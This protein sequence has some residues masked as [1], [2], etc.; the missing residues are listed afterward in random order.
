MRLFG[1]APERGAAAGDTMPFYQGGKWHLFFSQPP[2]GAWDY[3]ERARVS[4]AYLRSDDL[5]TWE[6]MPD[7]FG[8]GA[9]GNCD[10]DGIWTGSLIE[11]DGVFHFFYT[12]YNRQ[13]ASPQTI[14]KATS[15]DLINWSK[16][17]ANP[18]ITPDDRWYETVDW[19]DP[20]VYCDQ[21][22]GRFG[23]L[24]SARLKSGPQFR[25]G[26]IAVAT[27]DDLESW[28]VGPPL[29]SSRLTHCPECPEIFKL[30]D[31]WYLVE[32]RYS[33]RMQ[34]VYRVAPSPDGPWESRKLD[35]L[36]GR[37]FYAAKSTSDENRRISFAW[38]PFRKHHGPD[39]NWV[40]GGEL[41][42]PR[43]LISHADGTL[44]CR[45]PPEVAASYASPVE[46]QL[47][48]QL[49]DWREDGAISCD[50]T[51]SYAYVFLNGPD[52]NDVLLDVVIEPGGR[53]EAVGILIDPLGGDQLESG[54]FLSIEPMRERVLID[55]WPAAMD[56]LW[57]SLVLKER[58]GIEV[59]QEI[60]SPLVERPLMVTPEDG[61]YRVRLLRNGSALECFV[62]DQVVASFRIY[63]N[64]NT[65]SWGLFVQE[66]QASFHNLGF[67]R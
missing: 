52:R 42:S 44:T 5:V 40:W 31:W 64:S 59:T 56:P 9:H 6:V 21:E 18:L 26:C 65:A 43:E 66:G 2:V 39:S 49:G 36:D 28:E 13:S 60:D 25:R 67:R 23:M 14:C 32:S 53:T 47:Q 41:G 24:I 58:H 15:T 46:Y 22:T 35:S 55:R 62:A 7:A 33:E 17:A 61:R 50:A 8:P 38:I 10:G 27:S 29:A 30:G 4:T 3:V 1:Y 63:E 45:L 54:Y 57:D 34:T 37:R 19:R 16:T 48:P 12:G 20:Y 51:G 11:H